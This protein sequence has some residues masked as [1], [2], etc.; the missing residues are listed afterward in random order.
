MKQI[1]TLI[2]ALAVTTVGLG[3]HYKPVDEGSEIGFKIKNFGISVDGSFKGLDGKIIFSE[4]TLSIAH[5]DVTIDAKTI[6]TGIDQ[7]DNHLR[8]EDYFEVTKYPSIRFVSDRITKSTNKDYLFIFGK[9]TIKGI[10]REL[11]F[12]FK[13]RPIEKN[14]LLFEG[15]F[16]LDRRDFKVGGRSI[17]LSDKVTVH[18]KIIAKHDQQTLSTNNTP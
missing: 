9:L 4:D 11:S 6:N 7:R 12:P 15:E 5:F 3:Q 13:V 18:L 10:T 14:Q 17:T 1:L 2:A 8:S 16:G